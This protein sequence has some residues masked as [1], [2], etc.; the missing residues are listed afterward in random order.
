MRLEGFETFMVDG[1]DG[2][3]L[4]KDGQVIFRPLPRLTSPGEGVPEEMKAVSEFF[5]LLSELV[6]EEI[7][8]EN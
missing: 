8:D 5:A 2:G 7:P 6:Q 4:K 3:G 1:I